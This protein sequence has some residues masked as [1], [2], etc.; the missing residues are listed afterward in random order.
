MLNLSPMVQRLLENPAAYERDAIIDDGLCHYS[1]EYV[2]PRQDGA[3]PA[4]HARWQAEDSLVNL[5]NDD[6]NALA[7]AGFR[8][9]RDPD[10][11]WAWWREKKLSHF[12][13]ALT[14][15]GWVATKA[16]SPRGARWKTLG[17]IERPAIPLFEN[18]TVTPESVIRE[19]LATAMVAIAQEVPPAIIES[20]FF[21]VVKQLCDDTLQTIE[22]N[23]NE[24]AAILAKVPVLNA[25]K[26]SNH[27]ELHL[28]R[29]LLGSGGGVRSGGGGLQ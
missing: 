14:R 13:L 19:A 16:P 27:E 18:Y 20:N 9:M 11:Y 25:A 26:E 3:A 4:L 17:S 24:F 23:R 15:E 29:G 1:V 28:P 5:T 2:P 22:S 6:R 12:W 21:Q 8:V 10:G 7:R